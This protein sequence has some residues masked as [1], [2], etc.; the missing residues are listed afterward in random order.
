M[1][2]EWGV[3]LAVLLL[4]GCAGPATD[5]G[6][7]SAD[8]H[9]TVTSASAETLT[10]HGIVVDAGLQPLADANVT[11]A[12][13]HATL[14]TGPAGTFSFPARPARIYTLVAEAKGY[15]AQTLVARPGQE[16]LKFVLEVDRASVAP[17]NRQLHF[18][19]HADCAFDT[20]IIPAPCDLGMG[21]LSN[22][23]TF[24]FTTEPDWRT[25][26]LDMV[27]D[28]PAPSTYDGYHLTLRGPKDAESLGT[29]VQY[30]IFAGSRSFTQA[31]EPGKSYSDGKGGPVPGNV[32]Q[33]ELDA[34]M[35]G[36]GYHATCAVF[37]TT[38]VGAG[39]NLDFEVIVTLFYV[40]PAPEGYTARA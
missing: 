40:A 27:F 38:G 29:Y 8:G 4:A 6:S 9:A 25:M 32:T 15:H 13:D 1:R 26:V 33:F 14:R 19:G 34:Y 36:Y 31:I 11:L 21:V 28:N 17:Y 16:E 7:G 39:V 5:S 3:G 23:T 30:G 35:D 22:T 10:I 37:C 24:F 2:A 12:E 18:R 20:L